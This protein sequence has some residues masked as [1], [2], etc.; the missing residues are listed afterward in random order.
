M[1]PDSIAHSKG[2]EVNKRALVP[3]DRGMNEIGSCHIGDSTDGVFSN[4]FLMVSADSAK[5]QSLVVVFAVTAKESRVEDT[6]VGVKSFDNN[7]DIGSLPL[8]Q[9]FTTNC[10]GHIE[11]MPR[12]VK[13]PLTG[14]VN[15]N[16]PTH[17]SMSH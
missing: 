10:I 11:G 5:T 2:T 4:T 13:Y 12:R 9:E 15:P 3:T 6:V 17:K 14:M 8:E 16:S 1:N 7:S